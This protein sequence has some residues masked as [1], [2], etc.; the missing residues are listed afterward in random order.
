MLQTF[1]YPQ[2]RRNTT[3]TGAMYHLIYVTVTKTQTTAAMTTN[4]F[5]ER[6]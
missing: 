5:E 3:V 2:A 4:L 1:M 6:K